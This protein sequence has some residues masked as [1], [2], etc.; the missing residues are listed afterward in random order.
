MKR[1]A[2]LGGCA[3]VAVALGT[4][5]A[6]ALSKKSDGDRLTPASLIAESSSVPSFFAREQAS[7]VQ[8]GISPKRAL[9]ALTVQ[10][11]LAQTGLAH[12]IEAHLGS[13]F[14]GIWFE[15]AT[16]KLHI[17]VTSPASRHTVQELA[18]RARLA[19][20]VVVTTVRSTWPQLVAAQEQWNG[21]L[22]RLLAR[23][24]AE[25]ALAPQKN[26]VLVKLGLS[27]APPELAVLKRDASAAD[28]NVAL[29]LVPKGELTITPLGTP[30]ECSAFVTGLANCNPTITAGVTIEG[31]RLV[32]TAGPLATPRA[33]KSET[34]LLTAGHCTE[35]GGVGSK[36]Y[37]YSKS[38]TKEEIG[39]IAEIVWNTKADVSAIKVNNPGFWVTGNSKDPVYAGVAEWTKV[40]QSAFPVE[41]LREPMVGANTCHEGS[42]T[43]QLCGIIR[44]LNVGDGGRARSGLVEVEVPGA[45]TLGGDSGGPWMFIQ[46][47]RSVLMEGTEVGGAA[48]LA[49][50]SAYEPV[51]T[52]FAELKGLNLDLLTK[53]NEVR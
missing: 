42:T 7:L 29:A 27:V 48:S 20:D 15:P 50:N 38:G 26:A 41:G 14:A 47:N 33:T 17:G 37:A 5:I 51:G 45:E 46:P 2:V 10:S 1:L 22:A 28:V 49:S 32:C 3:I 19:D 34:Y 6:A 30:A 40:A 36:F 18:A 52:S 12:T 13:A 4:A 9:K 44:A 16:A 31:P 11:E 25:T 35:G 8:I 23:A 39:P 21:R 43:G 24:E 53:G